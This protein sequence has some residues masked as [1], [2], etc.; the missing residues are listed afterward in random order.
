M[1]MYTYMY[2]GKNYTLYI[3][4]EQFAQ[5]GNKGGLVNELLAKHYG[6]PTADFSSP[7]ARKEVVDI[8]GVT[9]AD[10]LGAPQPKQK[11]RKERFEQFKIEYADRSVVRPPHP[12]FGYPCCH[13]KSRCK[14]WEFDTINT[15]YKNQ[16]TQETVDASF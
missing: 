13:N 5:E 16:L 14:H 4:H 12:E 2:M 9:T 7:T 10:T 3:R 1:Y 6:D 11:T 15:E 8:P